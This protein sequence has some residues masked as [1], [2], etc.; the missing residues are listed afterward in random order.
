MPEIKKLLIA[1]RG[2]IALRIHRACHEMGIQTV[3][4]HSTADA[5]AMHV[6]LADQAICIGPPSAAES[7]LNIPRIISA[8]EISGADAIHPGYGFL[9]ENAQF[10]EIVEAH[11]I[12]FVG[13]KPEHIRT[14]GDK[15]EAKRTAGALGLP[16]VPGSDGA[17]S[18]VA[19]A[20]AI[21]RDIGYPVIIKAASGGGGRGMKVCTSEDELETLMQQA[22]SEAKA[23]FGDATVYLEKYLGNPRHIE[24][25]VFGDGNGHAIHLG[26]RDCSLQ[27]RHQKVLEE[28]PSPV[29][30]A[31]DRARMGGIVSKAMADMGYRGAGTIEFLWEDGEFYF[32][33]MNTRLQVEHPVTEMITG[34]DLVREQIRVAEGHGLSCR[35]EDIEFR[36]H[37]IEC[38]IN[39]E[40]PRSFAPSPGTV[41]QFHAPGGMHVR[42]D[43]GLYAGYKVP[44]YYDSMIAKLIVYGST[45]ERCLMRLRRAL[46]E[47]VIEGMKTTIPLHQALLDDPEFQAGDYTIKWLEEWLAKQ[48]AA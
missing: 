44:P 28:A 33:E 29:L 26:E 21:A 32:I 30:G 14:M 36:G 43:S 16:L 24:F 27:R 19:E 40:D 4:V 38:R 20:K 1:N 37:A 6:R 47:F 9:S 25:Q 46:E 42:V 13:P 18:D 7:Y 3:A 17:I 34:I 22:G 8:A 23:A 10:A 45:R 41:K 12:I 31:E 2:E 11:G 39:A 48:D 35:Q 5:D 15:V